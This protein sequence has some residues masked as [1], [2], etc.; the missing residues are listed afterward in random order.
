MSDGMAGSKSTSM[1]T[2]QLLDLLV[3]TVMGFAGISSAQSVSANGA[4]TLLTVARGSNVFIHRSVE[5]LTTMNQ[6][7]T[8]TM[9]V[10]TP[11]EC[12]SAEAKNIGVL[13]LG[14]APQGDPAGHSVGEHSNFCLLWQL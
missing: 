14:L 5:N 13:A 12:V 1:I 11:G 8:V 3:V 6:A 2:A 9:T 7:V 4:A 10:T